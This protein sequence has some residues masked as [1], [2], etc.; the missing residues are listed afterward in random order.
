MTG[1]DC[2]IQVIHIKQGYWN[3]YQVFCVAVARLQDYEYPCKADGLTIILHWVHPILLIVPL[4]LLPI[5]SFILSLHQLVRR[6]KPRHNKH[7]KRM[8]CECLES[9]HSHYI[10]PWIGWTLPAYNRKKEREWERFGGVKPPGNNL[11]SKHQA[12]SESKER[13]TCIYMY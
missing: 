13:I 1:Y 12:E 2:G 6:L 8:Q 4:F 7:M 3:Q 9:K 11:I 5:S 10:S